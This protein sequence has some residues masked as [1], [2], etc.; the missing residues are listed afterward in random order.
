LT[1]ATTFA[2]DGTGAGREKE[3]GRLR[4]LA[5]FF[6]PAAPVAQPLCRRDA[7]SPIFGAVTAPALSGA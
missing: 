1:L 5:G 3:T 6:H 7:P 4:F 2:R